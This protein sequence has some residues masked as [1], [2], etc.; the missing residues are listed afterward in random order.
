MILQGATHFCDRRF[1]RIL[2]GMREMRQLDL[3]TSLRCGSNVPCKLENEK[4]K[5][6]V[7]FAHYLV[8]EPVERWLRL[9][10]RGD[11]KTL[12]QCYCDYLH[13]PFGYSAC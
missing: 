12:P 1:R 4:T 3:R 10:W 11:R 9:R 2:V 13:I 5:I 8:E 7:A 6:K